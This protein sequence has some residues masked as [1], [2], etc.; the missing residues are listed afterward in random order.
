MTDTTRRGF[1]AVL[2]ALAGCSGRERDQT[3]PSQTPATTGAGTTDDTT[4]TTDC[5]YESQPVEHTGVLELANDTDE[6]VTVTVVVEDGP[7]APIVDRAVTV[8]P[9]G[10]RTVFRTSDRGELTVTYETGSVRGERDWTVPGGGSTSHLSV[11]V[12]MGADGD[13]TVSAIASTAD[14]PATRVCE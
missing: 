10:R 3:T 9:G 13:R 14:P 1:V 12:T 8:A 6:A 7:R 5:H 2:L 11:A 4:T